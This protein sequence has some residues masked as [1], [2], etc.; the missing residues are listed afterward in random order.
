MEKAKSIFPGYLGS[1]DFFS[2]SLVL[3]DV[4]YNDYA[5][6]SVPLNSMNAETSNPESALR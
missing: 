3:L 4:S 2:I 6:H 5:F 1:H